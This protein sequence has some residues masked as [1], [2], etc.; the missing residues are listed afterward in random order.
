MGYP[1][2]ARAVAEVSAPVTLKDT[3]ETVRREVLLNVLFAVVRVV[4]Q[5]WVI[6]VAGLIFAPVALGSFLL[7]RRLSSTGANLLQIGASQALYR[8]L[9]M[10][11]EAIERKLTYVLVACSMWAVV[12]IVTFAIVMVGIEPI[13]AW[14]FPDHGDAEQLA[15]AGWMLMLATIL[16]FIAH[17]TLLAER[18]VVTANLVELTIESG[19]LLIAFRWSREAASPVDILRF[20]AL[21]IMG[22]SA[23]ALVGYGLRHPHAWLRMNLRTVNESL[24]AVVGFGVLRGLVP[25]LDMAILAIG[26]WLLRHQPAQAGY[27]IIA[28]AVFQIIPAAMIPVTKIGSIATARLL[29]RGDEASLQE[30]VR[31]LLGTVLYG[32]VLV[33]VIVVPW[34]DLLL[35]LWLKDTF[36]AS[37]VGAHLA[38]LIW[39]V[40][41]L[42]ISYGVRGVI[43]IRW[44]HPKNL[45]TLMLAAGTQVGVYALLHH[46]L[47]IVEAVRASLVAA[48]WVIGV[49]T[50]MWIKSGYLPAVGYWRLDR[51]G[52]VA[53][54]LAAVNI[55]SARAGGAGMVL[56]AAGASCL[57]IL[58]GLG[59]S[60][61]PPVVREVWNFLRPGIA[62]KP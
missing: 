10:S 1:Q 58:I 30:Q 28:L 32:T 35:R 57:I 39:G 25:A 53:L 23:V 6:R 19:F 60:P 15:W 3:R 29:R 52:L 18:R 40:F 38:W 26:P 7:A 12:T 56:I 41:P 4:A 46:E 24:R 22:V 62:A 20:Q 5:L 48:F 8:Y 36:T 55:W 44:F 54:A 61:L 37:G 47:G 16:G 33:L 51:L 50:I 13:V 34:R 59:W 14:A 43:D 49:L 31:L 45:Y 17:A 21:G 9:P 2:P 42:A 11:G 27:L